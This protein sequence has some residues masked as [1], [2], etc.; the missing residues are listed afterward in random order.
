MREFRQPEYP[1]IRAELMQAAHGLASEHFERPD[2]RDYQDLLEFVLD[3]MPP[4]DRI[5]GPALLS[6][7]EVDAYRE[8]VEAGVALYRAV[9]RFA[10]YVEAAIA[11]EWQR[12][13]AAAKAMVDTLVPWPT[14]LA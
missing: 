13:R 11:P 9:G 5:L 6:E 14:M 4:A 8:L 10:P 3:G 1:N 2:K 12:M 7:E